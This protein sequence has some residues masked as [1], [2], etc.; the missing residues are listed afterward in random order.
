M[1]SISKDTMLYCT[2]AGKRQTSSVMAPTGTP[3]LQL[4]SGFK[5]ADMVMSAYQNQ[6]LAHKAIVRGTDAWTCKAAQLKGREHLNTA[7]RA[8]RCVGKCVLCCW[9]L[10]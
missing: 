1:V 8:G 5:F 9:D 10:A 4:H 2:T 6:V 7:S 3:R